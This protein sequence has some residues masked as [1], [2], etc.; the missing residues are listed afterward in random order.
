MIVRSDA[1]GLERAIESARP[2]VDHIIVGVDTRSDD[3]TLEVAH[4]LADQVWTFTAKDIG[5][6]DDEWRRDKIHFANAR[7]LGRQRVQTEWTLVIDSDEFI[8]CAV[9]LRAAV[10]AQPDDVGAISVRLQVESSLT[11]DHQRLTRSKFRW[12]AGTHNQLVIDGRY[13]ELDGVVVV[14]ELSLRAD[15]EVERRNRQREAAMEAQAAIENP[16]LSTIWHVAKHFSYNHDPRAEEWV[17]RFRALTQP[18]GPAK[19]ERA[20]LAIAIIGG[21]LSR[22]DYASAGEWAVRILHDGP[23]LEAFC[24]LGDIADDMGRT[25]EALFWYRVAAV[26]PPSEKFHLPEAIAHRKRRLADLE[27]RIR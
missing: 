10:A 12:T 3:A 4:C 18:N 13:V 2:H 15:A 21:L 26:T 8:T 5:L 27:A 20:Q 19:E 14:Q 23:R 6:S 22:R 9:D 17:R 25:E 24:I 7:N 16:D 11:F 1:A